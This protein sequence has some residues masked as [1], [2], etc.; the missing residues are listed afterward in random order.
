MR[1]QDRGVERGPWELRLPVRDA[2][3]GLRGGG[4]SSAA[5]RPSRFGCAVKLSCAVMFGCAIGSLLKSVHLEI[6]IWGFP[7]EDCQGLC[8]LLLR[9]FCALM[10]TRLVC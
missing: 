4:R 8:W 2:V 7:M 1:D 5:G 6:S 10:S 3:D 9:E